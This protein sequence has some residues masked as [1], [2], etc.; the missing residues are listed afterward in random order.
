MQNITHI[1]IFTWIFVLSTC[2][3]Q[4]TTKLINELFKDWGYNKYGP[5]WQPKRVGLN[6][7]LDEIKEINDLSETLVTRVRT[8]V[9]WK[10]S[11]LRW[12]PV[13]YDG[14]FSITISDELIWKPDIALLNGV[15]DMTRIGSTSFP[16]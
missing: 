5:S 1:V 2:S 13:Q 14:L 4:N 9:W 15:N 6:V 3:G 16:V 10:D 12:D 7:I 11:R 8:L